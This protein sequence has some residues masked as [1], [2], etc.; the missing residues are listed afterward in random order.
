MQSRVATMCLIILITLITLFG[1]WK[2]VSKKC[3][4]KAM[5]ETERCVSRVERCLKEV[6]VENWVDGWFFYMW[7]NLVII[8]TQ[9]IWDF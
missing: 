4:V 2:F 7:L 5:R 1:L 9:K 3:Q 6:R 8:K